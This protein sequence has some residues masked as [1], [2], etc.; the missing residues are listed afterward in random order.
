LGI[1]QFGCHSI[2]KIGFRVSESNA[3]YE[4]YLEEKEFRPIAMAKY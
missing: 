1:F 3:V 2:N 4:K